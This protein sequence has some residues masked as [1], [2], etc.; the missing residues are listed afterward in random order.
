MDTVLN[1][2]YVPDRERPQAVSLVSEEGLTGEREGA[3][4]GL[5]EL[6]NEVDVSDSVATIGFVS[7]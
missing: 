7:H 6:D 3:L 5:P 2:V 1:C 4:L